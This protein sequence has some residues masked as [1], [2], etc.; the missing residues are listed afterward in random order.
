[1]GTL[2]RSARHHRR[3]RRF[4]HHSWAWVIVLLLAADVWINGHG[5]PTWDRGIPFLPS[6]PLEG[7]SSQ[8][9]LI[10]SISLL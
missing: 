10:A 1:M 6:Q 9:T 8:E 3:R 4:T 2:C 7:I 5:L